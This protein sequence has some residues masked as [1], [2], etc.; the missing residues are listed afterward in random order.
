MKMTSSQN[1]SHIP[2]SKATPA[3]LP[4]KRPILGKDIPKVKE[5]GG[6]SSLVEEPHHPDFPIL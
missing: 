5:N 2:K 3:I 4:K 1:I 6:P